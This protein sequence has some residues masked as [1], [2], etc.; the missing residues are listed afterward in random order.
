M[1]LEGEHRRGPVRRLGA[2]HRRA[3]HRAMAAMDAVEI[4][5]GDD[6]PGQPVQARPVRSGPS[7]RT[8]TKG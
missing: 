7:S 4:A 6:R 3:D 5:D 2:F 8:T 1:R